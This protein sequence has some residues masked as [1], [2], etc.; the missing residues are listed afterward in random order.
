MSAAQSKFVVVYHYD[1]KDTEFVGDYYSVKV[2]RAFHNGV[3]HKIKDYGDYYHDRGY[4]KAQGFLQ[5]IEYYLGANMEVI[6]ERVADM[7]V[8]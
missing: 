7:E 1:K 2:Y 5:G 3:R 4:E 8:D 6:Y